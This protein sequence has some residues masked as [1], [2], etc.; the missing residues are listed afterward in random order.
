MKKLGLKR[1]TVALEPHNEKWDEYAKETIA[2][3]KSI[4][5][6]DA[7]DIQHVGSTAITNILAKPIIDIA[8]AVK[9]FQD[10]LQHE[11]TL[12]QEGIIFRGE[13]V[14]G[15]LLYIIGNFEKDTRSHH[16]HVV[17][18]NEQAWI[19]YLN[20]RDYLN[21]NLSA[22]VKYFMQKE[23]LAVLYPDNRAA[24]TEGKQGLID[25]LLEQAHKWRKE[26]E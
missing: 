7:V 11:E 13:D 26:Q 23:R 16:I 14:E 12:Q 19:N 17:K 2:V 4:L 20:F 6:S 21:H 3:L 5:G 24:Y 9:D 1:G 10:V 25:E 15:Q 8:V 18:W 22:A